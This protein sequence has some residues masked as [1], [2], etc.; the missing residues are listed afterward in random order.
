MVNQTIELQVETILLAFLVIY[1]KGLQQGRNRESMRLAI[2]QQAVEKL[3]PF[4]NEAEQKGG[5]D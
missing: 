1:D 2:A 5:H 4:L 3:R